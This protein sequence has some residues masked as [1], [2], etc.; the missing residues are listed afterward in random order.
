MRRSRVDI[1]PRL[2]KDF[3]R[4]SSLP[5]ATFMHSLKRSFDFDPD[6]DPIVQIYCLSWSAIETPGD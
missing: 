3:A 6:A 1:A 4:S 2:G 5:G